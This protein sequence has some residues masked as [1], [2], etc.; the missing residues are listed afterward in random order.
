MVPSAQLQEAL[1]TSLHRA[2]PEVQS[3]FSTSLGAPQPDHLVLD[4]SM[5]D[6]LQAALGELSRIVAAL[7]TAGVQTGR[8][9]DG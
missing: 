8:G 1:D 5:V 9:R 2:S 7:E 3:R 6:Q 4:D